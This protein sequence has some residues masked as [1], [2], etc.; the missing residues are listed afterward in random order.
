[1]LICFSVLNFLSLA[2]AQL[3]LSICGNNNVACFR[4]K[5]DCT[6]TDCNA[7]AT[8]Q[9]DKIQDKIIFVLWGSKDIN[10]V[11]FGQRNSNSGLFMVTI[12]GQYCVR[13]G[14]VLLGNFNGNSITRNT[15]PQFVPQGSDIALLESKEMPDGS[16]FCRFERSKTLDSSNFYQL[17]NPIYAA[18]AFGTSL[19]GNLPSYH[20]NSYR[21]SVQPINFLLSM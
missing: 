19:N 20:G 13:S 14:N 8:Y 1:M 11:A 4:D 15:S 7:V 2:I 12:R 3:D 6:V 16:F 21:I 17:T 10:W 5:E 18:I 9:F